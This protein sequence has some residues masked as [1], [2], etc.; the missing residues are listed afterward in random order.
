MPVVLRQDTQLL[1]ISTEPCRS[2]KSAESI[3]TAAVS[4]LSTAA[5]TGYRHAGDD[6]IFVRFISEILLPF[7]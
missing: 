3:A 7:R 1:N 5:A 2:D 4:M 6:R